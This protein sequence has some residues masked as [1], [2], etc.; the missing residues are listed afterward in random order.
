[1]SLAECRR[2]G[3]R[4]GQAFTLI[5][6]L[7]VIAI[8]AILAGLLLPAL[9]RAKAK[10]KRVACLSN[11]RQATLGFHLWAQ[12]HEGKFPWMAGIDEGGSQSLP[13]VA[14]YQF[15]L[16]S[17]EIDSPKVLSCP[18]DKA[19]TTKTTWNEFATNALLSL[20]YFAGICAG[21]QTPASLLVG[22]RNIGGLSPLSECTNATGMFSGGVRSSSFWGTEVAIHGTVGN[23]ALAD[24]SA[25][26]L[27]TF[28]LQALATNLA[29]RICSQNHVLLPCPEC[30]Q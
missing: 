30:A 29:P 5:E 12:D 21:E 4:A 7:V 17:R 28:G 8:V 9:S 25:H 15:L 23:V 1:M 24:G 10:A 16:V 19:V 14:F 22:D 26:Q 13:I 3:N 6:L 11:L 18:S 2:A 27:S 20:S